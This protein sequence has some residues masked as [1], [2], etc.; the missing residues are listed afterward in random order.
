MKM[1]NKMER[2]YL[3]AVADKINIYGITEQKRLLT[4]YGLF[5]VVELPAEE[6]KVEYI[7]NYQGIIYEKKI[8]YLRFF[9][10]S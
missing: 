2:N 1:W 4:G 3:R 8:L 5:V 6:Y 10:D 7:N 9:E